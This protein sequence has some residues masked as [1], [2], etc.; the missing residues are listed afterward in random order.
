MFLSEIKNLMLTK[1]VEDTKN[2]RIQGK[3]V[4]EYGR[5]EHYYSNT[6]NIAIKFKCCDVFYPCY[7][8][9]T[10]TCD[11]PIVRW[12]KENFDDKSIIC[13]V[14]NNELSF[15]EYIRCNSICP[16][17]SVRFNPGCVTHSHMYYEV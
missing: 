7:K 2:G 1:K 6:D 3:V 17:C 5:C 12:P 10:E 16:N 14:C 8:C 4:D 15:N 13:G 9:H 11:H